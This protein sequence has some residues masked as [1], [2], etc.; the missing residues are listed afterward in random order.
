MVSRIQF[1][2]SNGIW[3]S[4]KDADMAH[5]I[6]A[7]SWR[8]S[9]GRQ[10]GVRSLEVRNWMKNSDNYYLEYYSINCSQGAKI[11]EIYLPSLR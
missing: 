9:V 3:R 1:Q 7:V 10:Y 5:K 4:I 11:Q 8:N 6:D 2:D